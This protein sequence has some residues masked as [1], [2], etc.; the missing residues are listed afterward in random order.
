VF[1]D[2]ATGHRRCVWLDRTHAAGWTTFGPM[3]GWL[4]DDDVSLSY[5]ATSRTVTRHAGPDDRVVGDDIFA[6]LEAEVRSG[7]DDALWVGYFGY[8]ARS[9]LP[10]EPADGVPDA[11][12]MRVRHWV[13]PDRDS[14]TSV[15]APAAPGGVGPPVTDVPA[16]ER[17]F[18]T[19]QE[20]LHAGDSY[21]V[22]L[23][24]RV[25]VT[26]DAGPAEAYLALRARN[27]APPPD[28]S[29]TTGPAPAPGC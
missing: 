6:V 12:W 26:D 25:R 24:Y 11:V 27:A 13:T 10:A 9:D 7:P 16:Y 29:S 20:H 23:T 18:A 15:P 2:V 3:I 22:N 4:D 17:A 19:I 14:S 5:D 8:A 28:I 1:R 21:E